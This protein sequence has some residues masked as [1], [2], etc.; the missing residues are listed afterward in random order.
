MIA[1]NPYS[2]MQLMTNAV[3]ILMALCIFPSCE[4]EDWEAT[5]IK[6]YVIFKAFVHAAYAHRLTALQICT[7]GEYGYAPTQNMYNVFEMSD[8]NDEAT[9]TS[10]VPSTASVATGSTFASRS[11]SAPSEVAAA[12]NQL[13]ANQTAIWNQMALL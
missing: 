13:S 11:A 12:I 4:F 6:T 7:S 10:I 2:D 8:T 1:G 5:A 3:Q 9:V